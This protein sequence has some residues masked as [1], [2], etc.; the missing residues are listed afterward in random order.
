MELVFTLFGT[1]LLVVQLGALLGG[2]AA[3]S[4]NQLDLARASVGLQAWIAF[5]GVM[6][7]NA[8]NSGGGTVSEGAFSW[9]GGLYWL[10]PFFTT[11][12]SSDGMA[13]TVASWPGLLCLSMGLST[14]MEIRAYVELRAS[15]RPARR[16]PRR[17]RL[18]ALPTTVPTD[19]ERVP[20]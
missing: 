2:F 9:T 6:W 10:Q 15:R 14:A 5:A 16:Q 11:L 18:K 13:I 1:L 4:R 12:V 20:G 8:S 19:S 17:A 7:V 3:I